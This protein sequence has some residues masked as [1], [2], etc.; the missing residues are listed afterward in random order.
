MK[1]VAGPIQRP[2]R[3]ALFT[4]LLCIAALCAMPQSASAQLYV[5]DPGQLTVGKYD[6]NTGIFNNTFIAPF[7][8][9][10]VAVSGNTL[11]L[12]SAGGGTIGPNLGTVRTYDATTGAPINTSFI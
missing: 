3:R 2:L 10:A 7:N 8:G 9:F 6:F 5:V 1:T 11:F 4:L 12:S